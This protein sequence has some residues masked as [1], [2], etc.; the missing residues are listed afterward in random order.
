V[1]SFALQIPVQ[2]VSIV[3]DDERGS[4]GHVARGNV[5]GGRTPDFDRSET[6]IKKTEAHIM[7]TLSGDLAVAVWS[8]RHHAQLHAKNASGTDQ[9][10]ANA[11]KLLMN[12]SG[13]EF[14]AHALLRLL[15][16]RTINLLTTSTW[17]HAVDSVAS[18]LLVA[19]TLDSQRLTDVIEQAT[20]KAQWSEAVGKRL[21]AARIRLSKREI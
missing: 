17:W 15:R 10:N 1:A 20:D 6:T 8:P 7:S 4:L 14:E 21:T 19:G 11:L 5:Y 12:L 13:S 9:D 3:G 2:E 18:A 16:I